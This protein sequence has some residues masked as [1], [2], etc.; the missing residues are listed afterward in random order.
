MKLEAWI[1]KYIHDNPE[2]DLEFVSITEVGGMA[3][4]IVRRKSD[5]QTFDRKLGIPGVIYD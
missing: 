1:R 4:T 2:C 5:G 3:H